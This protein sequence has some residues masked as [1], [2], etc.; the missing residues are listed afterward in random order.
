MCLRFSA[1]LTPALSAASRPCVDTHRIAA[2]CISFS[3]NDRMGCGW[4]RGA[5]IRGNTPGNGGLK[6][7]M[8]ASGP[9]FALLLCIVLLAAG[10]ASYDRDDGRRTI[11]QTTDDLAIQT[12][13]KTRLFNDPEISGFTINTDVNRGVVT[14]YGRVP[15]AELKGRALEIAGSV[16]GVN[17]VVD[18]LVI[19]PSS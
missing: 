19:V 3:D 17:R 15:S 2:I 14:L 10:C 13:V 7:D 9:R 12:I 11:G 18:K 8:N 6:T 1:Y 5:L 16:R 4:R